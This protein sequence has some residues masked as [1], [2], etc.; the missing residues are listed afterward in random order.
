[1][2]TGKMIQVT[3]VRSPIGGTERQRDTLRGLGLRRIGHSRKLEATPA[4]LGMTK[5]VPHLVVVTEAKD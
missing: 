3:L 4:V 1:M 2:K 5:K